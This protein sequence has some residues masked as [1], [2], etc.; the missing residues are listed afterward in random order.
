MYIYSVYIYILVVCIY[1][2]IVC[3]YIYIYY[4]CVLYCTLICYDIFVYIYTYIYIYTHTPDAKPRAKA[5]MFRCHSVGDL[6]TI[7]KLDG[8]AND[9]PVDELDAR[10]DL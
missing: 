8:T 1:I 3:M 10:L 2:Y 7:A 9:S 4:A 5:W 6:V